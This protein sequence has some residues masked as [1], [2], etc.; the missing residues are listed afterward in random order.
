MHLHINCGYFIIRGHNTVCSLRSRF[1][2]PF[3]ILKHFAWHK[4]QCDTFVIITVRYITFLL[5]F[6]SKT[7]FQI[8]M[9][10]CLDSNYFRI[11]F[12]NNVLL[13]LCLFLIS[14]PSY[15]FHQLCHFFNFFISLIISI[16]VQEQYMYLFHVQSVFHFQLLVDVQVVSDLN[17]LDN[18]LSMN[19]SFLSPW[20]PRSCCLCFLLLL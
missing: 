12:P 2:T 11:F 18:V 15:Q 7:L 6:P 1:S 20:L 3:S 5:D 14:R 8:Q 16:S 19:L 10:Y 4:Q 17:I 9:A 13:C